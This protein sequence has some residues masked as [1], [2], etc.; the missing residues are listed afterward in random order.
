MTAISRIPDQE[1]EHLPLELRELAQSWR[2]GMS[3]QERAAAVD[4]LEH[5]ARET[6]NLGILWA[7]EDLRRNMH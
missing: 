6:H 5:V 2:E 1:L 3:K 4:R 7:V